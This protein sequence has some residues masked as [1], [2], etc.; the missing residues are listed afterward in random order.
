MNINFELYRIFYTVANHGN[1]TK[2]SEE[3]M[4][5]QP[6]ISKSIKNLEEQLGG[7]LFIRTKRGVILT[8]EGKEF[9]KYIK[10]AMEYIQNA[11]SKFTDLI[12][13]E[14]GSIKIGISTTLTKEFLLPFLEIFHAKYPNINIEINTDITNELIPKLR[15]GLIDMIILNLAKNHYGEDIEILKIKEIHDCFVCNKSFSELLNR[16]VSI[17]ELAKYP[18]ILLPKGANTRMFVDNLASNHG[19]TLKP[20]IELASIALN[21]EFARIGLGISYVTKEYITKNLQDEDLYEID[22]EEEIPARF[23]GIATC[24]NH[25]S[26]FSSKKLIEIITNKKED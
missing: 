7:T 17:K 9:Y 4:I 11:E 13:L 22:L 14:T 8:D 15:N 19:V 26:N 20:N 21:V 5:S 1:I 6:A 12:N 23:I 2:A 18:L 25:V 3:L 10:Q 16:K 24:K